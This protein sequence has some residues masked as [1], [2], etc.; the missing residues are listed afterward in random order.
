MTLH[1]STFGYLNPTDAQKET[2]NIL[3]EAAAEYAQVL[4]R[5]LLDGPDKTHVLRMHRQNA[6]WVNVCVT[7][8]ADGTPRAK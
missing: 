2:M 3:R 4:E 8:E 5:H 7:R 1:E 6:M